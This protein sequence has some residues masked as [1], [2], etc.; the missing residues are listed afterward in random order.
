MISWVAINRIVERSRA[1]A[2]RPL[3]S[4]AEPLTDG[5]LL[6]RL[7]TFGIDLDRSSLGDLCNKALSAEEI[8]KPLL[9][10]CPFETSDKELEGDWIWICLDALWQRWFPDQ[11]SF[12]MLDDKM[13]A[14]YE[15]MESREVAAACHIWLEAWNDILHLLDKASLLSIAEFDDR[16]RGTQS[17]FNWVQDLES[18][19]WNAG[20]EDQQFLKAR[21]AICEEGL[22]RFEI[23][24]DLMTQNR[25]CALAESYYELGETGK[26]D[27]LYREWLHSDPQWGWGW[28]GWSDCYRFTR[29]ELKD[30]HKAE[31]LLQEGL[32][33]T[34]VRDFQYLAERLADLYQEQGRG[35]QAKQIRQQSE[36][37]P[38]AIKPGTEIRSGN[39]SRW[40]EPYVNSRDDELWLSQMPKAAELLPT[41]SRPVTG[42]RHKIGRNQPCPCGSGRKFKKCCG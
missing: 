30:L 34:G 29:T 36:M 27:A 41:P 6:A 37:L 23:D 17:L 12:E 11:P 16:F 18:E 4:H 20:L 15:L 39:H 33:I 38:P 19:L 10:Q 13:Q 28:I 22:R 8:A 7:H 35:D 42:G 9:Q 32:S 14:G 3:R 1:T 31:E 2:A 21:I 5:E 24:D 26:A 25:R 40:R